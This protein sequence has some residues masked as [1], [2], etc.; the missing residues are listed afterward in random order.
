MSPKEYK[1]RE[2]RYVP[3]YV[4]EKYPDRIAVF[5]N[6]AVGPPPEDLWKSH[7]EI[8]FK[9]FRRWRFWIDAVVILKNAMVLIEGKIR[10]PAEGIGQ[11]L[12]YRS[13]LPQTPELEPY[14]H[15]PVRMVIVTP[16]P[17][18]R[19]IEFANT[20]GLTIDIYTKPWVQEYLRSLGFA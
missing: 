10:K 1:Q 17:D 11:V 20:Y 16:R 15:L 12:L 4:N 8:P 7:P 6:M 14:K 13:L 18:P 9:H 2:K 3:E 19:I 5:Y